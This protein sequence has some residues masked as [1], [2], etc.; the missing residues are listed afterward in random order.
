MSEEFN[1]QITEVRKNGVGVGVGVP[2]SRDLNVMS[3]SSW[4]FRVNLG[5]CGYNAQLVPW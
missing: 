1:V 4:F 2:N 5:F 3:L